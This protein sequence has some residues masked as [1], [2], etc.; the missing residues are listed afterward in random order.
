MGMRRGVSRTLVVAAIVAVVVVVAVVAAFTILFA[1]PG[2]V[3]WASTQ[4]NPS[5][6]RAFVEGTL[7]PEFTRATGVQARFVPISYG[8]LSSRLEAEV[9]AGRVTI[10]LVGELHGGLDLFVSKGWLEDLGRFGELEGRTFPA[11]LDRFSRI[12]GIKAYVPWMTAT[13]V[14]VVN[15]K[16][17]DYLPDGLTREDV[18]RGTEKWSYDAL[19]EWARRITEETGERKLGFPVAPGG[20]WHRFLHGYIYPSFTGAQVKMFNSPEA[21]RLWEYL[22][23]LW[24][25]VNPAS[26]TWDAMAEPLLKEEVLIAWDHTARIKDAVTSRPDQFLVVPAPRGPAGRGFILVVAGL[27]IPKG[28]PAQEAA[29]SLV[30]YLTRPSVQVSVLQNVGFF[31]S[32]SEAAGAVPSGP[33]RIMAEGVSNQV[34]SPDALLAMIPSLGPRG[35]EFTGAYRDAFK[36]IVLEGEDINAVVNELGPKLL[37]LFREVGA[38]L[39]PPDE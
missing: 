32:V 28:A 25:Y 26:T 16:A 2:E 5:S 33:L 6:E 34:N 31:P 11:V 30:E 19:L 1:G 37:S 24:G 10:S 12:R 4:L 29:W 22:R 39:P 17:F 21:V 20:L 15:K 38:P 35:G 7:L 27:A 3:V 18:L 36:R 14:F 8:D 13:Y 23:E 9:S